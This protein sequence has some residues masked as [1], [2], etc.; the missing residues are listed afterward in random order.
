MFLGSELPLIIIIILV[1]SCTWWSCEAFESRFGST[2]SRF[3]LLWFLRSDFFSQIWPSGELIQSVLQVKL[4]IITVNMVINMYF[5]LVYV[6]LLF[7]FFSHLGLN[8]FA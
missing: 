2:V 1:H 8:S 5:G 7:F 4:Q 6:S 3:S